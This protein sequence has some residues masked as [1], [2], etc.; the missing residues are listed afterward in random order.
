MTQETQKMTAVE[1][2]IEQ[3]KNG[4]FE[5]W[6]T[7]NKWNISYHAQEKTLEI[8]KAMEK[9]QIEEAFSIGEMNNDSHHYT[10]RKIHQDQTDY[11]NKTYSK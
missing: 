9:E 1:W 2:L 11:F 10:G 7:K 5:S 4:N 8:A 6:H 3:M